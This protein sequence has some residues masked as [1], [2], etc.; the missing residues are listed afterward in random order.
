MGVMFLLS[1]GHHA[2]NTSTDYK[3]KFFFRNRKVKIEK[4]S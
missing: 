4:R 2:M 1:E 3:A